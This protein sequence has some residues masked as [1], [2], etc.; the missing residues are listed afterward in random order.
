[1][2]GHV[3]RIEKIK[4]L[5]TKTLAGKYQRI[6]PLEIVDVEHRT[7]FEGVC[8]CVCV[9]ARVCTWSAVL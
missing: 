9:C 1:M 4:Y 3:V 6:K 8:V 7:I 5:Y 2:E